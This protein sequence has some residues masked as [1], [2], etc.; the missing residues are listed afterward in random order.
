MNKII[1]T[2]ERSNKYIINKANINF[3]IK[4]SFW[5]KIPLSEY[6]SLT[7]L[8]DPWL[9]ILIFKMMEIGGDFFITGTVSKSLI[10]NLEM[11]SVVWNKWRP[12]IYKPIRIIPEK[13]II[14]KIR[15]KNNKLITTFSGGV[16]A[17]YTAYKYAKNL[18]NGREYKYDTCVIIHGADIPLKDKSRFDMLYKSSKKMTDDLKLKLIPVLTNYRDYKTEKWGYEFGAVI[19]GVLSFFSKK[20]AFGA[21]T[22][23]DISNFVC[24]W[25]MNLITDQFL[26]SY[27]FKFIS[28]GI[29]HSRIERINIIKKWDAFINNMHV[30]WQNKD[31]LYNCGNCEKCVRTKLEFL[32][33]GVNYLP[34][35]PT[36]FLITDLNSIDNNQIRFFKEI[37]SYAINN[38]SLS[39][40]ILLRLNKYIKKGESRHSFWWHLK[41]MKF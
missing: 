12:D 25:G 22:D 34:T 19:S 2:V 35:M 16:D 18:Q 4:K 3:G 26:S 27:N 39:K 8:S 9:N 21:A 29:E 33:T 13:T 36:Q 23:A 5:V 1:I 38:K 6:K 28:D 31:G 7:D 20:F 41:Y 10:S 37:Y 15:V 30:C 14:D 32:A 17:A 11:F 40:K 24:P